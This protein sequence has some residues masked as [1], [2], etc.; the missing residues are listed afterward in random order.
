MNHTDAVEKGLFYE[1][2]AWDREFPMKR[3]TIWM[4]LIAEKCMLGLPIHFNNR[5]ETIIRRQ[6]PVEYKETFERDLQRHQ[7]LVYTMIWC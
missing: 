3:N 6:I 2:R 4:R 1:K 7:K 5:Y